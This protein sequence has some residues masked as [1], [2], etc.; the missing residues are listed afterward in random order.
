MRV[1][2][3]GALSTGRSGVEVLGAAVETE[4][5]PGRRGGQV[6]GC[7]GTCVLGHEAAVTMLDEV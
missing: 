5:R 3:A 7:L 2:G 4:V 1:R 6:S